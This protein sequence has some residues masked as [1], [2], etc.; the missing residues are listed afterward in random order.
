[1]SP[2]LLTIITVLITTL[3]AILVSLG[4]LYVSIKN[5]RSIVISHTNLTTQIEANHTDTMT[6][7]ANINDTKKPPDPS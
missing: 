4:T 1:M 2:A 3:P 5:G 7:I 6:Q